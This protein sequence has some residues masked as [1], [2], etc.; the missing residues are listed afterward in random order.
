[1]LKLGWKLKGK[2]EFIS[3]ETLVDECLMGIIELID[4]SDKGSL[5]PP[6]PRHHVTSGSEWS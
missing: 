4:A 2:E 3:N 6:Q 1:V 5:K